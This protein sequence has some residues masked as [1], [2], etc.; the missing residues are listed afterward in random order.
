MAIPEIDIALI[1]HRMQSEEVA[2]PPVQTSAA[3]PS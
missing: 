1:G 3:K 2:T